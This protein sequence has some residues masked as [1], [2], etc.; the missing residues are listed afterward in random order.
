MEG[1]FKTM[2]SCVTEETL[3]GK[4]R[5]KTN[6]ICVYSLLWESLGANQKKMFGGF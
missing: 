3:E 1:K 2:E 6:L 4:K 5:Q